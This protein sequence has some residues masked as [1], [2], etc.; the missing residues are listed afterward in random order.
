MSV[1]TD[2]AEQACRD[3][4]ETAFVLPGTMTGLTTVALEITG[5]GCSELNGTVSL[6]ETSSE[7]LT[8][9]SSPSCSM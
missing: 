9:P 3:T 4:N 6:L 1:E 7:R 2:E 8:A 5:V